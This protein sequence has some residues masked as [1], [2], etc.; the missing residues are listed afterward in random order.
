MQVKNELTS[1]VKTKERMAVI[2]QKLKKEFSSNLEKAIKYYTILA[3]LNDIKL[4]TK[5]IELLAFTSV[6]GTITSPASRREFI[7]L[8]SSSLASLENIK[9]KLV[10]GN[11]LVKVDN[12]YR[13]NPQINL[14]FSKDI[15]LQINLLSNGREV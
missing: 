12:K 15:I 6:K 13:T 8:F 10:K 11:W 3:V 4:T 7:E 5:Q 1:L 9:G 2:V 14:D